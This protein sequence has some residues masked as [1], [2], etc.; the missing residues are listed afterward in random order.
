MAA[1]GAPSFASVFII[2]IIPHCTAWRAMHGSGP[3]FYSN[4]VGTSNEPLGV[5]SEIPRLNLKFCLNLK[6]WGIQSKKSQFFAPVV[7]GLV[8]IFP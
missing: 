1:A 3:N 2:I 6:W 5:Q 8:E 7:S 4:V